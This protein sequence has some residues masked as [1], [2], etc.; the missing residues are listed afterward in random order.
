MAAAS[1][2][3]NGSSARRRWLW[4]AR[5][6]GPG[7]N[8]FRP[9]PKK[10]VPPRCPLWAPNCMCLRSTG[11]MAPCL[12]R[13]SVLTSRCWCT[14]GPAPARF[15]LC[16]ARAWRD[17]GKA[18]V[19]GVCRC[20]RCPS[21]ESPRQRAC[22]CSKR[23]TAFRQPGPARHGAN[24]FPNRVGCPSPCCGAAM[25]AC[26]WPSAVRCLPKTWTPS[27]SCSE[28]LHG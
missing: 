8:L 17:S 15:A 28:R 21:T 26:C 18:S 7:H 2:G 25:A 22:I 20:W 9:L 3:A 19:A 23:A 27:P 5:G 14:G 24:R 13:R 12:I 6:P 11:S 1:R 16:K 4:V 10:P